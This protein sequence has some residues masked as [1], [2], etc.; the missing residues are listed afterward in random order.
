[1]S[2][3]KRFFCIL[4]ALLILILSA[5]NGVS[6]FAESSSGHQDWTEDV[7]SRTISPEEAQELIDV[8]AERVKVLWSVDYA[9]EQYPVVV[10][11]RAHGTDGLP[12]YAFEYVD[13]VWI[14]L[15]TGTGPEFSVPVEEGG[16]I[17]LAVA[18][19]EHRTEPESDAKPLELSHSEESAVPKTQRR[20]NNVW[21]FAT[22]G[23]TAASIAAALTLTKRRET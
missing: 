2:A 19:P 8:P 3:L 18:V 14:L 5:S 17:S 9:T 12:I 16:T 10:T 13:G 15:G 20:G 23:I 4:S 11:L 1:M 22:A 6:A 7:A 21:L